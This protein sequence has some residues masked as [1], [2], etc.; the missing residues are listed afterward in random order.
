MRLNRAQLECQPPS[1]GVLR[2]V[3]E[4]ADRPVL[5]EITVPAGADP[6]F[7][8][9]VLNVTVPAGVVV[10]VLAC[11]EGAPEAAATRAAVTLW[12]VPET[13]AAGATPAS[14]LAV[15][16]V[17]GRERL[18]LFRYE[19]MTRAFVA[20]TAGGVGRADVLQSA[21]GC[22]FSIRG[23]EVLRV[24]A[25]QVYAHEFL[26]LG[27]AAFQQSPRLQFL[28]NE[29]A[30]AVLDAGG[31]RVVDLNQGDPV[32]LPPEDAGFYERFEFHADGRLVATLDATGLT[33]ANLTEA[34]P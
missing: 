34:L 33:A 4:T 2:L 6:V 8:S 7:R 16:W 20:V 25:G 10:R 23:S 17:D 13:L 9:I 18:P 12:G 11:Y 22:S 14:V 27:P 29:T 26:G 30:V 31:L 28:I 15:R 24:Q 21:D 3:L 1:A 32:E 5:A 19:P